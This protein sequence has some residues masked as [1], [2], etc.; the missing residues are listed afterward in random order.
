MAQKH[1][2]DLHMNNLHGRMLRLPAKAG[3]KRQILLLYGHHSSLERLSSLAEVFNRY[4]A[5][6]MPDLPGFGGMD[7]FYKIGLQPSLDNYADY[8]AAFIKLRYKKS[9]VTIVAMSF[10]FLVVTRM[11]QRYPELASKVDLLI[12]YVGFLHR[13]DFHVKPVYYW[14]WRSL[15]WM[16]K[17]RI[18]SLYFRYLFLQPWFIRFCY[19]V[20]GSAHPKFKGVG[21]SEQQKR[22]DFEI[23]LWHI[24]DVR[25]R[26]RTL[27]AMLT[28]DLCSQTINLPVYHVSV[29]DDFYFNNS[30]V[31]QHMRIVY[32][33]FE[34]IPIAANT[35]HAPTVLA[36]AKQAS[37]FVPAKLK[38]MLTR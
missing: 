18:S 29:P 5:V 34:A 11:L 17:G 21:G 10:S 7:S 28:I 4:G 35:P 26:M 16:F 23:Q 33:D 2:I 1:I 20:M 12:S 3:K 9:Q 38:R 37:A 14:T 6:T 31:E 13:D 27:S 15:A 25:T 30:V 32:K 8:L 36:T 24:N 19:Q 22:V